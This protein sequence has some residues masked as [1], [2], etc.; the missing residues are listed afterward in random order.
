MLALRVE[1]PQVRNTEQVLSSRSSGIQ[2]ILDLQGGEAG[3]RA[4]LSLRRHSCN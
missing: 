1:K 3:R 4:F 2:T